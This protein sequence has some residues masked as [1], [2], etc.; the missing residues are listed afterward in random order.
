M[1]NKPLDRDSWL[2]FE[3]KWANVDEQMAAMLTVSEDVV[4]LTIE[5]DFHTRKSVA[6][7]VVRTGDNSLRCRTIELKRAP[8]KEL[9]LSFLEAFGPD[10]LTACEYQSV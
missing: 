2:P 4:S 6:T 9:I 1:P 10:I 3:F 5:Y 8:D 7:I